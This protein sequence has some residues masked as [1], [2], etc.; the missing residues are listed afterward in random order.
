MIRSELIEP[1][2]GMWQWGM[3]RRVVEGYFDVFGLAGE[4]FDFDVGV[5]LEAE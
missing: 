3:Q 2:V 1:W 4:C 5:G